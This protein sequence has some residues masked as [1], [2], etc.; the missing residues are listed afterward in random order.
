MHTLREPL[1]REQVLALLQAAIQ[2]KHAKRDLALLSLLL[3]TGMRM[4]E[5]AALTLQDAQRTS[6]GWYIQCK[7][8]KDGLITHIS[9]LPTC[10]C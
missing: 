7:N 6:T 9:R 1:T 2:S 4:P 8:L 10:I 3:S 5:V